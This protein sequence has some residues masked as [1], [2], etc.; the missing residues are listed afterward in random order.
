MVAS[1]SD[2]YQQLAV[3]LITLG[4]LI[5]QAS[6]LVTWITLMAATLLAHPP[7]FLLP[8]YQDRE[9]Y[10]QRYREQDQEEQDPEVLE[11]EQEQSL[12]LVQPQQARKFATPHSQ[13][14]HQRTRFPQ[15]PS[16]SLA[17]SVEGAANPS[18]AVVPPT[19]RATP[20][21]PCSGHIPDPCPPYRRPSRS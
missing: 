16:R 11:Q 17:A 3:L 12:D 19:A 13:S 5:P 6:F 1:A 8:L 2:L 10:R 21:A 9:Q 7:V 18:R 4:Q 20:P 15:P 14:H